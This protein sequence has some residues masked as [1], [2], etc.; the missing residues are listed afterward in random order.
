MTSQR[1][2]SLDILEDSGT[3]GCRPSNFHMEQNLRLHKDDDGPNINISQYRRLVGRLL[4][5][6]ITR[7]DIAFAVNQLSK[8][9]S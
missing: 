4:Y 3:Q 5:L 8:F 1:K 2:Y 9:L 7:L 6:N